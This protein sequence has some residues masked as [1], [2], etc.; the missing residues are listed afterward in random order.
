MSMNSFNPL[1][2]IKPNG[3]TDALGGTKAATPS[4]TVT[5][6]G[7]QFSVYFE[8]MM[9]PAFSGAS[10]PSSASTG[11]AKPDALS[12]L[13]SDSSQHALSSSLLD[14]LSSTLAFSHDYLKAKAGVADLKLK[15][16]SSSST[17]SRGGLKSTSSS[18]SLKSAPSYQD[19][20]RQSTSKASNADNAPAD[21]K[22]PTHSTL[23]HLQNRTPSSPSAQGDAQAS[24]PLEDPSNEPGSNPPS[25]SAESSLDP[26]QKLDVATLALNEQ[27]L[28]ATQDVGALDASNLDAL[29]SSKLDPTTLAVAD[30]LKTIA[31]SDQTQLITPQ[32]A[33]NEASA[34]LEDSS[35]KPGSNTPSQSAESS[36][37]PQQK[38]DV[39]TLA[40]NEQRLPATQEVGA[41]DAPSL[42]ALAST[43]LDPTTLAVAGNLKT[44]A[45]SDQTQLITPQDAPNEKSLADFARAMGFDETQ[46]ASLF[47][48]QAAQTMISSAQVPPSHALASVMTQNI[49]ANGATKNS[50]SSLTSS[51]SNASLFSLSTT[52]DPSGS[53]L[54]NPLSKLPSTPSDFGPNAPWLPTDNT[55][56]DLNALSI[57]I[58]NKPNPA[59]NTLMSSQAALA[60][61]S[62]S[63]T[64]ELTQLLSSEGVDLQN[65]QVSIDSMGQSAGSPKSPSFSTT[66]P[67]STLAVLNMT[68]S[69]LSGP[70][71]ASLQKE[72]NK[73]KGI[74]SKDALS[75]AFS[76]TTP[77]DAGLASGAQLSAQDQGA[78]SGNSGNGSS[79]G[80]THAQSTQGPSAPVNMA[81]TYEKLSEQ[82]TAELS[83]RMHEQISQGQWKMKFAL[84]P[85]TLGAV[86]VQLEMKDGKLAAI[87]Q[88]DNALTQNL[89]Q[90][91]SQQL[92]DNLKD[93]GLNQ[94]YVQV[95]QQGG[96]Q[97][98][99]HGQ[100]SNARNPFEPVLASDAMTSAQDSSTLVDAS[101]EVKSNDSLLDLMA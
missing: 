48:P 52:A 77:S 30:S 5:P 57:Q 83:K 6:S 23:S 41:L 44:I 79:F 87:F 4:T 42:D 67:T 96:G 58:N 97:A 60:G 22:H 1:P 9:H 47:G 32:D 86:D 69:K 27:R 10:N 53:T 12:S 88:A 93:I 33:P 37:D 13:A 21:K 54:Q 43:K 19:R 70:A 8:R 66:T 73:L 31:L 85:S 99:D 25:Q 65:T 61:L 20:V 78:P 91:A 76:V 24:A 75:S 3:P 51:P 84:K 14:P 46:V 29:V 55:K 38:L 17:Q 49:N 95:D 7:D 94:T 45:L 50:L 34:P 89:L 40:L 62:A 2:T 101:M 26:Q 92:K 82:L 71:I 16:P 18:Q 11:P 64:S 80:D 59:A 15:T 28:P 74:D 39:A 98:Q 68:G 72:F 35:T 56:V 63:K 81:E 36:L 90:H 100:E